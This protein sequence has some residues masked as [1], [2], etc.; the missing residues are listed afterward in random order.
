MGSALNIEDRDAVLAQWAANE[1]A[2]WRTVAH[3]RE[4]QAALHRHWN[5]E[6]MSLFLFD[7][8]NNQVRIR[9][10]PA[11]FDPSMMGDHVFPHRAQM[12]LG[13]FQA[14][15]DRRPL[16]GRLSLAVDVSD[17]PVQSLDCPILSFQKRRF[18]PNVLIPDVDFLYFNYDRE[19]D[20]V[21]SDDKRPGAIFVGASTGGVVT[22]QIVETS[23]LPRLA[24]ARALADHQAISFTI[25]SAV[26]C[27]TPETRALLESQPYFSGHI[28]WA[29]QLKRR[30]IVSMDGNGAT[31]SRVV[32]ALLSNS[33]LIK[34]NS[35][36]QLFYFHGLKA[37]E[38][39]LPASTIDD[40]ER[41]LRLDEA[42]L[43]DRGG[44]Q[45]R[46]NMF[47]STFLSNDAIEAYVAMLLHSIRELQPA[48]GVG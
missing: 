19:R 26:Q 25:G 14:A 6:L 11:F 27:D 10:K 45:A 5:D 3:R 37:F 31:C 8:E 48:S 23:G 35:P 18:A 38:H 36:E 44:I 2:C 42:G 16:L 28:D 29:E 34:I 15:L 7:I 17:F 9:P 39:F 13:L 41:W 47:A 1:T 20:T 30:F 40:I 46:A 21:T 4:H 43:V 24:F 32:R 33:I 22:R 12:Y